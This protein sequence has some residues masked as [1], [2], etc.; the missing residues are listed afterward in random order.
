[1]KK[2]LI[3][4]LLFWSVNSLRAQEFHYSMYDAA[5]LFL[6]PAMTGIV[7]G[8]WRVHAQHR[9]QWST[10]N[11]K[12]YHHSHI[13]YDRPFKKWGFGLNVVNMR[14]GIGNYNALQILGSFAYTTPIDRAKNHNLSFGMQGG[15]DQKSIEY[16]LY[17]FNNQY[18]TAQ[19]GGFDNTLSSGENFNSNKHVTPQLNAGALYYFSKQQARFNPFVGISAFNLLRPKNSFFNSDNRTPMRFYSH[20]GTRI[21]IT[22]LFYLIPKVLVMFQTTATEQTFALDAGYYF[23]E[24]GVFALGGLTYRN[25]D[26]FSLYLGA[27]VDNIT[28]KIGYD[29]NTSTLRPSSNGRGAF[30]I[31][32][33]YIK[34]KPNPKESKICPRL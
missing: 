7:D 32:I 10:V 31:S 25:K 4:S 26:A 19:G 5:P 1:M 23:K 27:R 17:T 34:R 14:A 15:I 8:D 22:E 9:T 2:I 21:N 13:S 12:P 11:F 6:N 18:V 33:T 20:L 3:F 29:I 24:G 30:E 16:Q 28:T